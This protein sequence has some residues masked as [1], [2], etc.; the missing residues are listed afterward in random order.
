MLPATAFDE[1][2]PTRY[3]IADPTYRYEALFFLFPYVQG[4]WAVLDRPRFGPGQT[5]I[6]KTATLPALSTGIV[7]SAPWKSQVEVNYSYNFGVFRS[8]PEEPSEGGQTIFVFW[9]KLL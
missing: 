4:T 9:A 2:V 3:G 1:F 7:S 6:T 8:S 5:I